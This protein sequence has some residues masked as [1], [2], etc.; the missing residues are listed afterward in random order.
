MS[1]NGPLNALVTG[2]NRGIGFEIARQLAQRGVHVLL[3]GRNKDR[4]HEAADVLT[5][6]GLIVTALHLDTTD[7]DSTRRAA[8]TVAGDHGKLDILVNNAAVR[9]EKYGIVPSRQ[10]L[11][12]WHTT[13]ETNIFGVVSTT[14]ALLPLLHRAIAARIVNVSSLLGSNSTHCDTASYAYSDT[15]KSLP[16][17][18]ASKSALNSWTIHLAY[19]L[20]N[21]PIKVNSVHPGY[22]RTGL[23]DGDGD[24]HPSEG[25]RTS[26]D[27]A[28]LPADGPTGTYRHFDTTLPW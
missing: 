7:T 9:V 1:T 4:V 11:S 26:V 8:T 22:T 28:L 3:T 16:A 10:P 13:F 14:Q 15:F 23:N 27:M 17:Y 19:E 21:T 25:A 5:G 20:R 24:Q 12:D 2:A 18:S 6:E